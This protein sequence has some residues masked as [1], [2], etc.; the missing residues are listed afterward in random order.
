MAVLVAQLKYLYDFI[1]H[2]IYSRR[3]GTNI[4][5]LSEKFRLST[6]TYILEVPISNPGQ[7]AGYPMLHVFLVSQSVRDNAAYCLVLDKHRFILH[8]LK[9]FIVQCST[10]NQLSP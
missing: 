6:K 7:D 10:L 3:I 1:F 4:L 2:M 9:I 8:L 5:S